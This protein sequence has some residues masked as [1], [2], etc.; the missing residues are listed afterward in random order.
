MVVYLP[1]GGEEN[2]AERGCS[3]SGKRSRVEMNEELVWMVVIGLAVC[4]P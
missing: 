1:E 4:G 3:G 2:V